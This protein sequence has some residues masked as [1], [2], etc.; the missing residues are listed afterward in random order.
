MFLRFSLFSLVLS[1]GCQGG[2][3]VGAGPRSADPATATTQADP[4]ASPAWWSEVSARLADGERTFAV[5]GDGFVTHLPSHGLD[6]RFDGSGATLRFA[7]HAMTLRS[8]GLGRAGVTLAAQGAE[9]S[10]GACVPGM[11]SADGACVRQLEL[12]S[13]TF[14]EWWINRPEGLEQGW[15]V[16]APPAGDGPLSL[17]VAVDGAAVR[18]ERDTVWLDA[19]GGNTVMVT[20]LRAWDADG[21]PLEAWFEVGDAGLRVSVDD[22]GARFPITVDPV[23]QS[24]AWSVSGDAAVTAWGGKVAGAGDINGDGYADVLVRGTIGTD[25][26]VYLFRGSASGLPSV[27]SQ[28]LVGT[29]GLQFGAS[30]AGV[31]DVNHDGYADVAIGAPAT[32]AYKGGVS[33]YLGGATGLGSTP[34]TVEGAAQGGDFGG[35][36]ADACDLNGDNKDDLVVGASTGGSSSQGQIVAYLGTATGIDTTAPITITGD[37]SGPMRFGSVLVCAGDV[38]H[39]LRDD[40]AVGAPYYS[41]SGP[42]PVLLQGRVYVYLGG[43]D[44]LLSTRRTI[45]TPG[46]ANA[47]FGQAIAAAH[48]T[49]G[50]LYADLLIASPGL[51]SGGG[52]VAVYRGT[53]TGISTTALAS[54]WNGT[55]AAPIGGTMA[56]VGDVNGDTF[57]DMVFGSSGATSG[58]GVVHVLHGTATGLPTSYSAS[59]VSPVASGGFGAL[60]A[61]AGDVNGDGKSD[62]LFVASSATGDHVFVYQGSATS[63]AG[64]THQE[65]GAPTAMRLGYSVAFAGDLN[66]DT[67]DDAIVGAPGFGSSRGEALIYHGTT[68]GLATTANTVLLGDNVGDFYGGAVSGA[69]DVNHDGYAD[70]AVGAPSYGA[71]NGRVYVYLGSATGL[72]TAAATTLDGPS[73]A[74]GFGTSLDDAGDVNGDTRSDLLVGAPLRSSGAG[75]AYLFLG[76]GSGVDATAAW[77]LAGSVTGQGLGT[78]V[79]TAGDVNHDTFADVIVGAPGP[80]STAGSALVFYG[81]GA[82][83]SSSA[84]VTLTGEGVG[85]S[86]GATVAGLGDTNGDTY[87]EVAVGAPKRASAHGRVYLYRGSATGLETTPWSTLSGGT[88]DVEFGDA[89]APGGDVNG[90][91]RRD[92]LVGDQSYEVTYGRAYL[93]VSMPTGFLASANTLIPGSGGAF[94]ASVDGGGDAN[95]DGF[96]DVLVGAN[97]AGSGAYAGGGTATLYLGYSGDADHDGYS[98]S[99]DCNDTNASVH[100]GGTEVCDD[101][102]G[103]E[104]CNG[105]VDD[106]DATLS[107]ASRASWYPDTDGDTYGAGVAVVLCDAPVGYVADHTDCDDASATIRPGG[108]EVCDP[109]NA[110]EDCDGL[111]D[112]GDSS[113]TPSTKSTFYVDTDSDG[114]GTAVT[115]RFCDVP[116]G[117]ATNNTDCNDGSAAISPG[118]QEVCDASNTDEDC[119]NKSDDADP[120][121]SAATFNTFFRDVDL[122][123]YGGLTTTQRCDVGGGA[124]L[125]SN[126]CND[127]SAVIRPGGQE[128][129]DVANVDEDCDG[130]SDNADSSASDA[131][132]TTYY[133][134]ADNDG[135]GAAGSPVRLCDI[136]AGVSADNT[137]CNDTTASISP[138]ATEVCDPANADEDCDGL[139][140]NADPTASAASKTTFYA[141]GDGDTYGGTTG[142]K[143]CDKPN[144]YSATRDDCND[145]LSAINPGAQEVCDPGDVDE[146]CDTLVDDAD[147]SVSDAS[148]ITFYVDG[149][150]DGYGGAT[151]TRAC[152]KPANA[153]VT[154]TDCND[155]AA[156]IHPGAQEVC[157]PANADEDCDALVDDLDPSVSAASRVTFYLDGDADGY[158]S[159]T[160]TLACDLPAGASATHD[161]CNDALAAI[162]PGA[163]E[164][165]DAG[166][167]DED[168]DTLADDADSSVSDASRTSFYLDADLDGFGAATTVRACD[169]TTGRT[170][171]AGDCNDAAAAINP[172]AQEVC[173]AAN[174]DED[175]DGLMDDA[176]PSVSAATRTS[177]YADGDGDGYGVGTPTPMCD[178]R[179]GFGPQSGDCNDSSGS[180]NPGA[181]EVCDPADVDEDCD[182]L[183]DDADS[184]TSVASKTSFY[185][186]ADGDGYGGGTPTLSCNLVP[187]KVTTASDCNDAVAAIHPGAAEVC[188]ASNVDEDCD[189]AAD[190]ADPSV[191]TNS[192]TTFHPDADH[193][194]FGSAIVSVQRCDALVGQVVDGTDCN[195]AVS[196]T[197]PGATEVVAD[198]VDANCDTAELCYADADRDGARTATTVVSADLD[199][200]DAGEA[201]ATALF[202]CDDGDALSRP[203][204]AELVGDGVDEDCDGHERCYVDLD[205]DSYRVDAIDTVSS[206]DA[207][208]ADAGEALATDLT[209][210]CD[211]ASVLFHPN[212]PESDCTDPADYNCDGFTGFA[213]HDGDGW[214]ACDDCDD[215][216]LDVRP[217]ASEIAGDGLDSNCDGV[218]R[219]YIDED[220]DGYRVDATN[221]ILGTTAGCNGLGEATRDAPAGDCTDNAASVHP[222]ASEVVGDAIDEDCDGHE[223]CYADADSDGARPNAT[224]Q[225]VSADVDCADAGEATGA[226]PTDD[227]N[228]LNAT[229]RPGKVDR[230]GD[231]VDSDCDGLERC[232]V[233]L[234]GDGYRPDLVKSV[235]SS[236]TDCSDFGEALSTQLAGDC[237]DTQAAYHPGAPEPDC[238]DPHDYNCDNSVAYV[239]NDHD[240]YAACVECDDSNAAVHPGAAEL[241]GDRVDSNCDALELCFVDADS[242]GGRP[243]STSTLS[244]ANIACDGA[245]EAVATD[246]T[247]DC[248]DA[249]PLVGPLATELAAD[250]V[251][252]DCNGLEDCFAD[253][254]QDGY[255]PDDGALVSSVDLDCTDV[256]EAVGSLPAGDCDDDSTLYHPGAAETQCG[257]GNDYNCDGAT[258]YTDHDGDGFAACD[259]CDDGDVDINPDAVELCNGVD[260]NCDGTIDE[261]T[262]AD[263]TVWFADADADGFTSAQSSVAACEPPVGFAAASDEVDCDDD[264]AGVNPGATEIPDDGIDQDCLGGDLVTDN[265][266]DTDTQVDDTDT[267]TPPDEGGCTCDQSGSP[268]SGLL[269][270]ILGLGAL[271][272]RRLRAA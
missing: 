136:T 119:D 202:D 195:D 126:D 164:V 241:P 101:Y 23:Y 141:D 55:A 1:V 103:D 226:A 254:D 185:G 239:D 143:F 156:A 173:D 174:A 240:A 192:Q 76:S 9:P 272:R 111:T 206:V 190:D 222:D 65:L 242:D 271:R 127:T 139:S 66:G 140:D 256:G 216:N 201:P 125:T 114:Y 209:G 147:S 150:A 257:D 54:P 30:M 157:D 149:D 204:A 234:D 25:A 35:A 90:D 215:N 261:R 123:G 193:D 32:N 146:D 187:G 171:T 37:V 122:D 181:T 248:D 39:D 26:R 96:D 182:S 69:G 263:A 225:V 83:L 229:V 120:S 34:I 128:V 52:R 110:D 154:S 70:V 73:G 180:V 89:L 205:D 43:T 167:V 48:D 145:T 81:S 38:N 36:I 176:D 10:L 29:A 13:D 208:C 47:Y 177:F 213:D 74:G 223:A 264:A 20:D 44:G 165:C 67:Y 166:N 262:A 255:R 267:G 51:N 251:D 268:R 168:C 94:A 243:D 224:D 179:P 62:A 14:T 270:L 231:G 84:D 269:G 129:C 5:D 63:L 186:D 75:A 151:T 87:G 138:F 162:N 131:T 194:G 236:D 218:D 11:R 161:D 183:A 158:G 102:G 214:P 159:N 142:S 227:C 60:V 238:A 152:A 27:S 98:D 117:Y 191:A 12:R 233:D 220:G 41:T 104:N 178:A 40:V 148:K 203:G 211:D 237:D 172:T 130:L 91:G 198:G 109:L 137:D 17:D 78:K 6:A 53:S 221:T 42:S 175:C 68:L 112:N 132:R 24:S 265:P 259:E 19:D 207:D 21:V 188:D 228:D 3:S 99:V 217:D 4:A 108:Q 133:T 199:C 28:V 93:Y 249:D 86:F 85:D 79:A 135:Y 230:T 144:G 160:A 7:D 16:D 124:S 105:S 50:D 245:G 61:A 200:L 244:S 57:E 59:L 100:P 2:A 18:V 155:A 8:V 49:N 77:S 80:A 33:L 58:A 82:G 95:G 56:N 163:T 196:S 107:L 250:G 106:A 189:S 235:A 260:D 121:V 184:S 71:G 64:G 45:I 266:G 22:A 15:T 46:V 31:G 153:T 134:D 115:G 169:L 247:T 212:A 253:A 252:Q 72:V 116:A 88:R 232:F 170:T 258:G 210:D 92:L 118:A 246:P 219:C 113:A 197:Y 97:A